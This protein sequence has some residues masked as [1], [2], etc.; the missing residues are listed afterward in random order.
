MSL[1]Y[2]DL[3]FAGLIGNRASSN[4]DLDVLTFEG[5]GQRADEV[6]TYRQLWDNGRRLGAG[7]RKLRLKHG[8]LF[9][10]L[11]ANHAE[12]VEAMVAAGA[13]GTVFVP[14]DP[15]T[16]G[17]KLA[18]MLKAA[19]CSGVIAA[20]YALTNVAE[21]R[22]QLP[23]L[24][25]VVGLSTDEGK[26]TAAQL[27]ADGVVPYAQLLASP[28]D[29]FT[30]AAVEPESAMQLIY[31]SGTTGDPKGIV[32]TH[33]RY[34]ETA[35]LAS[36]LFGF[37]ADDRPYSGLS[38]T[39]ANAQVLTLGNSLAAGMRCVLSRRFTKSR[40]WDITRHYGC[41]S[42]NLLGGMTTAVYAE[43]AKSDDADNPVRFV[44]SAG[45]PKAIWADF[46]KRFKVQILE[47]YGAAE[48]G[49]TVKPIG[50]GPIGSIGKTIPSLRHR[51]VDDE[52]HEV[53][54]GSPGELLFRH[55]DGAPFKVEYFGNPQAS[56]HKTAGGWLHMGDVV[57]EDADGWLFFQFRKG[58]GIRCN[59]D[60]INPAF[61]EKA[62]AELPEIDD[63]YVYGVPARSGVPGEK[64]PVA[65]VVP[66]DR[67]TFDAQALFQACRQR[68][69]ANFMPRYVQVL[70]QIPKTASEK[71]QERF[72][73]EAFEAQPHSV[74]TERRA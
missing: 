32:M 3:T 18:Y 39:H 50:V 48:G 1:P 44:V 56:A 51:I 13:T 15:R 46:E 31:T 49:L 73:V 27:V 12:F 57:T 53:T 23:Q 20:D 8:D 22:G 37:R 55:A 7:L 38:L 5:G 64:D 41:T 14:I 35:A 6:R 21:I 33:K 47:F 40:L 17:D 54:R 65:A 42:F 30:L 9:G 72:L 11:M 58:G 68:L 19:N 24:K 61:V 45:M 52:G 62:I 4:P 66:K 10:V 43:P 16:K 69:E 29:D 60:F 71:P 34:C 59:G 25:W 67:Q 2:S 70:E 28:I 26:S 63:V 36:R 74:F